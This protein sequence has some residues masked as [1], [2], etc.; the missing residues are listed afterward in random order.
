V[1]DGQIAKGE[2]EALD[3]SKSKDDMDADTI[4]AQFVDES[5]LGQMND[6]GIYEVQ[7]VMEEDED[8]DDDLEFVEED[9]DL[10]AKPKGGVLSSFF[11]SFTGQRE[12]TSEILDPVLATVKEHL[13]NQNVASDISEHLCQSVRTS[14]LG[15]KLG[16]FESK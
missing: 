16:S 14:L 2:M 11:K 5:K 3:Y 12:I 8:E 7:D 13:I 1:W 10:E 15:K 4:A 6:E 9:I